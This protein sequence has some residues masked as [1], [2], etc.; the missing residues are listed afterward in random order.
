MNAWQKFWFHWPIHLWGRYFY[1]DVWR[2]EQR[3]IIL[4]EKQE[5]VKKTY[6]YIHGNED[7]RRQIVSNVVVEEY[8]INTRYPGHT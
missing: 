2:K 8:E 4:L 6:A 5:A 7:E 1:D 3:Q